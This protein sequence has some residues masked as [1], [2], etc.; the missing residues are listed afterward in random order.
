MK[1]YLVKFYDDWADEFDVEGFM[2]LTE[3]EYQ[4]MIE[5]ARSVLYPRTKYFGTNEF[6]E[7]CSFE[8]WVD[9]L[10][11]KE[12]SKE[13]YDTLDHVGLS[14]FGQFVVPY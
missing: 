2:C 14:S 7:Y 4:T 12:I 5:D 3:S 9:H 1:Y 11:I 13:Q 10:E 8:D 6:F